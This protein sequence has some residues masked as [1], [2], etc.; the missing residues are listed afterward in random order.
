M[1]FEGAFAVAVAGPGTGQSPTDAD[2][3][4]DR[5]QAGA[6]TG[7]VQGEAPVEVAGPVL[8]LPT[9][10]CGV[11]DDQGFVGA[12]QPGC[13]SWCDPAGGMLMEA[14]DW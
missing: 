10:P 6:V 13:V 4:D 1:A 3:G 5:Q 2:V 7:L 14:L 8:E 11:I 9:V 12:A